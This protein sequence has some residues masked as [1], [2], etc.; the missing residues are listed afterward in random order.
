MIPQ[1]NV[2]ELLAAVLE[3]QRAMREE[4]RA[5]REAQA[6]A[7]APTAA[8]RDTAVG[9]A[10]GAISSRYL[11]ANE[12]FNLRR[13]HPALELLLDEALIASPAELAH[14]LRRL[15]DRGLA[16]KSM[17]RA[18]RGWRWRLTV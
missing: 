9:A 10:L 5:W 4:F 1:P 3:E 2:A 16:D 11:S 14:L 6:P 15:A 12:W 17:K 8:D 13:A 7:P 18:G